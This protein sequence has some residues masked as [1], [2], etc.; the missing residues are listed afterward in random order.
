MC[1]SH[2]IAP[3]YGGVHK[4]VDLPPPL[5]LRGGSLA[6]PSPSASMETPTATEL[7]RIPLLINGEFVQSKTA[8]WRHII[9]PATQETL[10]LV[11]LATNDE[12]AA[13][14]AAAKA[15]FPAWRKTPIWY[16]GDTR[17]LAP[18]FITEKSEIDCPVTA[19]GDALEEAAK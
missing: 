3:S 9:N 4:A 10:A 2:P 17:Q 6:T 19:L 7:P 16:G 15:A 1:R 12:L 14:V 13:A 11:P 5:G 18:P 8:Q